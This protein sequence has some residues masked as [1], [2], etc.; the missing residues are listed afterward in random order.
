MRS[1]A[2][3]VDEYLKSLPE[4][5]RSAIEEV[6]QTILDNLPDGDREAMIW[7]MLSFEVSLET[8]PDT[9]NDQ[10]IMFAALA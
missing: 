7:G 2:T 8:F 6:R 1:D 3:T 5:R 9:S 10:P 4:Y